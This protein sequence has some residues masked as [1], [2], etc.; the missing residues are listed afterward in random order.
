MKIF[1]IGVLKGR[2]KV[3]YEYLYQITM[4]WQE[5]AASNII[6]LNDEEKVK[7]KKIKS[8]RNRP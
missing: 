1:P 8:L 3:R 2:C 7:R 4:G 6:R 5:I